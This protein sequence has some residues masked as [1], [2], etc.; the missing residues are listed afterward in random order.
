MDL[1]KLTPLLQV[2]VP[3]GHFLLHHILIGQPYSSHGRSFDGISKLSLRRSF[4]VGSLPQDQSSRVEEDLSLPIG[5]TLNQCQTL[6]R[7][8]RKTGKEKDITMKDV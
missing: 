5:V 3:V 8:V 7:A 4:P 1:K 2:D 6:P